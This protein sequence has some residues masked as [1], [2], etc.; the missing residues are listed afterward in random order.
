LT[1]ILINFCNYLIAGLAFALNVVLSILPSSPFAALNNTPV[2][3]YL[4][5]VNWFIP[6]YDIELELGAFCIAVLV[7]YAYGIVMRWIKVIG[8]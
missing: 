1:D 8:Q 4:G 5:Y 2:Q 6:I 7:Y 3:Q